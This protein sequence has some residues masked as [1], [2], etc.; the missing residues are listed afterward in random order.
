MFDYKWRNGQ[1]IGSMAP[2]GYVKHPKDKHQL[3]VD[4]DT[5]EIVKLIFEMC[6]Q[7]TAK[8][9]TAMY[10]NEH[11]V[12]SPSAYKRLKRLLHPTSSDN[13][14]PMWSAGVVGHILTNPI[15]TGDLVQGRRV[16][17]CKVH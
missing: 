7:G 16:K 3:M 13:D 9:A 2:Y 15:Y 14:N 1:Y 17:S 6:L 12:P 10:L 4:P 11:G 8:L 5:A